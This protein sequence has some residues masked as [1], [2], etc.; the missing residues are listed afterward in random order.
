MVVEQV[1]M[2]WVMEARRSS[3]AKGACQEDVIQPV[4]GVD[5]RSETTIVSPL[6]EPNTA[7]SESEQ[8]LSLLIEQ[9]AN[10]IGRPQ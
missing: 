1:S 8:P 5:T 3:M 2:Q 4:D 9:S 10:A 6:T 7:P